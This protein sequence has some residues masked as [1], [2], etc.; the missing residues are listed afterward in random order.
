VPSFGQKRSAF[1]AAQQIRAASLGRRAPHVVEV[2][3][4]FTLHVE[5]KP[6]SVVVDHKPPPGSLAPRY[7]TPP[8][9]LAPGDYR[10][11]P[12]TPEQKV[13]RIADFLPE[14]ERGA[15]RPAAPLPPHEP[16]T[17]ELEPE[18]GSCCFPSNQPLLP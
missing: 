18:P 7:N 2:S 13:G 12:L 14:I 15:P 8:G 1:E 10:V 9:A 3:R 16:T 4:P 6:I 17:V 5:P 11:S